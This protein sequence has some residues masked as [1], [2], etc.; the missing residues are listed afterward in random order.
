MGLK[1]R[2]VPISKGQQRASNVWS[3]I[4]WVT[5]L[6][7][8]GLHWSGGKGRTVVF[9]KDSWL[10]GTP[11]CDLVQCQVGEEE[12]ERKVAQYR[13][14][15]A[16]WRWE[17]LQD[18]LSFKNMFKLAS[19]VLQDDGSCADRVK[20]SLGGCSLFTVKDAYRLARGHS[21]GQVWGGWSLIWKLRV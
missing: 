8:R 19:L 2:M 20:W 1:K 4:L 6:L 10:R 11:L 21:E 15:G 13:E 3:G 14:K 12:L 5:E 9:W 17:L 16:G 7:R 18:K